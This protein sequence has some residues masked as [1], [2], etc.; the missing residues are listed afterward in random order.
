MVGLAVAVISDV[1][2]L[3]RECLV[4]FELLGFAAAEAAAAATCIRLACLYLFVA[5][6]AVLQH[7]EIVAAVPSIGACVNSK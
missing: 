7:G 6:G 2:L 3:T 4:L 5:D 1:D